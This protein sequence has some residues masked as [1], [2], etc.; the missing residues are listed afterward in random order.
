VKNDPFSG[1]VVG[2][3]TLGGHACPGQSLAR[4]A[5]RSWGASHVIAVRKNVFFGRMVLKWQ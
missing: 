1:T 4:S 2:C 5:A 3:S